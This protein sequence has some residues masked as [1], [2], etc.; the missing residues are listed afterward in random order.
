MFSNQ[1]RKYLH[2][3]TDKKKNVAEEICIR[4]IYVGKV[5]KNFSSYLEYIQI[6][7]YFEILKILKEISV[8]NDEL[9][10][11]VIELILFLNLFERQSILYCGTFHAAANVASI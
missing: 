10:Y 5:S 8:F 7:D 2:R 1:V 9:Q 11:T 3:T 4:K 6:Q